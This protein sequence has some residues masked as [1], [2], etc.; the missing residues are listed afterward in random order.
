MYGDAVE[1]VERAAEEEERELLGEL[2]GDKRAFQDQVLERKQ[3]MSPSHKSPARHFSRAASGQ[4]GRGDGA[5]GRPASHR[6]TDDGVPS[7]GRDGPPAASRGLSGGR[8]DRAKLREHLRK[9]DSGRGEPPSGGKGKPG[10]LAKALSFGS[11]GKGERDDEATSPRSPP[12]RTPS[13]GARTGPPP[14]RSPYMGRAPS[15]GKSASFGKRAAADGDEAASGAGSPSRGSH[16]SGSARSPSHSLRSLRSFKHGAGFG[17]DGDPVAAVVHNLDDLLEEAAEED[18]EDEFEGRDAF[19]RAYGTMGAPDLPEPGAWLPDVAE[20]PELEEKEVRESRDAELRGSRGAEGRSGGGL[21]VAGIV[22]GGVEGGP[23]IVPAITAPGG[24]RGARGGAGP[25][26]ARDGA[27]GDAAAPEAPAAAPEAPA[28]RPSGTGGRSPRL[29]DSA[30]G[31][32][33]RA[34]ALAKAEDAG[35]GAGAQPGRAANKTAFHSPLPSGTEEAFFTPLGGEPSPVAGARAAEGP[36][37]SSVGLPEMVAPAADAGAGGSPR[38]R[39]RPDMVSQWV[40]AETDLGPAPGDGGATPPGRRSPTSHDID[41]GPDT[42]SPRT[43][44]RSPISDGPMRGFLDALAEEEARGGGG[45]APLAIPGLTPPA[46][47]APESDPAGGKPATSRTRT[48][49]ALSDAGSDGPPPA[50]A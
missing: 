14:G 9:L 35:L 2:Y 27:G 40:T 6:V 12:R 23:E 37:A 10:V 13:Q 3:S 15:F 7:P 16:R 30:G 39:P 47:G 24:G 18:F 29:T 8:A 38:F 4:L 25:P 48:H 5:G 34:E 26:G 33:P 36:S 50:A 1:V 41:L 45:G 11:R 32:T 42:P 22:V 46:P 31:L 19:G 20:D 21:D 43:S 17:P 44:T 28:A 49:T